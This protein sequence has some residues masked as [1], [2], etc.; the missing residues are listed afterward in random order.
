MVLTVFEAQ[1]SERVKYT[2][3]TKVKEDSC[4]P[5][6]LLI[7]KEVRLYVIEIFMIVIAVETLSK[8]QKGFQ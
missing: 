3:D 7:K 1:E 4:G 8:Y 2:V 5:E 6:V